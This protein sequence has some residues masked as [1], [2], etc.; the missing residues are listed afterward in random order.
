MSRKMDTK[1]IAPGTQ[2]KHTGAY[3]RILHKGKEFFLNTNEYRVFSLLLTGA[4]LATFDIAEHLNVPDPRSTVR[5]L[6][7]MGIHISDV[8][9]RENRMR[10]K[11]YFIHGEGGLQ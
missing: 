5:Y 4:K 11:R 1:Q 7:K 8:W 2:G 6:R 10:F 3:S 9:V